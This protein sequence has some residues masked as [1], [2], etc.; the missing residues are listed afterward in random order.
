MFVFL[1][2]GAYAFAIWTRNLGY[3][4]KAKLNLGNQQE[5]RWNQIQSV[6]RV[7]EQRLLLYIIVVISNELYADSWSCRQL[8]L[9]GLPQTPQNDAVMLCVKNLTLG[10]ASCAPT[11]KWQN[12]RTK[13]PACPCLCSWPDASAHV[14]VVTKAHVTQVLMIIKWFNF[15]YFRK[16]YKFLGLWFGFWTPLEQLDTTDRTIKS[17]DLQKTVTRAFSLVF[18]AFSQ[19]G[20][21][22]LLHRLPSCARL[23]SAVLTAPFLT[24][25]KHS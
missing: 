19:N 6:G 3:E 17:V 21:C 11:R 16:T 23:H 7:G 22:R 25:N 20:L 9:N 10:Y 4:P 18:S 1:T 13:T 2:S 14:P 8:T 15:E 12:T 24:Q 5:A